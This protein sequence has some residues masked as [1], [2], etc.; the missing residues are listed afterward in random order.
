M[1]HVTIA[2]GGRATRQAV[3]GHLAYAYQDSGLLGSLMCGS[4]DAPAFIPAGYT[5]AG[6]QLQH[7]Q[8]VAIATSNRED[9]VRHVKVQT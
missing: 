3:Y 7:R 1:K 6:T 2:T 8:C 4:L 5:S 9:V